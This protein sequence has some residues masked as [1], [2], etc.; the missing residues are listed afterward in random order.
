[1]GENVAAAAIISF[2]IS[3]LKQA[4]WFPWL[5]TETAKVNRFLAIVLSGVATLGIHFSFNAQAHQLL[6]DGLSA[7][8]IAV[9][10]YHW[11]VQFVYTHGW[12][13]ATS[14]SD[15]ILQLLKQVLETRQVMVPTAKAQM[16]TSAS[17]QHG[18]LTT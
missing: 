7:T 16:Q 9:G 14:A 17:P 11:F 12:F 2:L 5:S 6:I 13:K 1:M 3:T 18:S 8:T 15:Q 10:L 4:S